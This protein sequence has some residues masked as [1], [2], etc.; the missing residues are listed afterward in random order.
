M[1]RAVGAVLIAVV[2]GRDSGHNCSIDKALLRGRAEVAAAVFNGDG[3]VQL[4]FIRGAGLAQGAIAP[5]GQVAEDTE[6]VEKG[7]DVSSPHLATVA[8]AG[9][10]LVPVTF[11]FS[12][13]NQSFSISHYLRDF[14]Q[15][16]RSPRVYMM[17]KL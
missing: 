16:V 13:E 6:D 5:N 9:L 8:F 14:N 7:F 10:S 12:T 17:Q 4:L 15:L 3:R 2:R 1:D 11:R